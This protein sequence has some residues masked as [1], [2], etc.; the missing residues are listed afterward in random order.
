MALWC[1]RLR[2]LHLHLLRR[3]HPLPWLRSR[4]HRLL[5]P[6]MAE[7]VTYAADAFFDFDKA[8]LKP[9]AKAKLDDLVAKTGA[10]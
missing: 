2:L 9:E 4:R 10:A 1:R 3:P 7:K 6:V 8:V 5:P